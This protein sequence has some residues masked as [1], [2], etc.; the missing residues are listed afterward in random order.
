MSA[1]DDLTEHFASVM[2]E[3][4]NS[5]AD[6]HH[7]KPEDRDEYLRIAAAKVGAYR[8]EVLRGGPVEPQTAT[9]A[10][11]L[12]GAADRI[13]AED[14]PQTAEDTADFCDGARWATA[15]LRQIADEANAGPADDATPDWLVD[16]ARTYAPVALNSAERGT[17]RY[18]LELAED[19]MAAEPDEFA[20]VDRAAVESLKRLAGEPCEGRACA[21][22][23]CSH[24]RAADKLI[25]V[26]EDAGLYP[27]QMVHGSDTVAYR[28]RVPGVGLRCLEHAPTH[29]ERNVDWMACTANDLDDSGLCSV[30][31]RDVLI[32]RR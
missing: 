2:Y 31:G 19:K 22:T 16:L 6:W 1:R 7:A 29:P 5:P 10:D 32:T 30:C 3:N 8:A 4:D 18:A 17:L 12:R 25:R 26:T 15:Q 9:L 14:L 27:N 23:G 28:S 11:L 20:A 13:D 24:E 21:G